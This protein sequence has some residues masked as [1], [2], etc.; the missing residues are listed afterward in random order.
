L[1]WPPSLIQSTVLGLRES[2]WAIK[3]LARK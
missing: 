1:F 3:P 2:T